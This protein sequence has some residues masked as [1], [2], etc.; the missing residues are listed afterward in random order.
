MEKLVYNTTS[1]KEF[2]KGKAEKEVLYIFWSLQCY[3]KPEMQA[4][5]GRKKTSQNCNI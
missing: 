1:I 5:V 4:E 2:C 3:T